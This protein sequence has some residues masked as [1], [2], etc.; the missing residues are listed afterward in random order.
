MQESKVEEILLAPIN[1]RFMAKS[2]E[3]NGAAARYPL[4]IRFLHFISGSSYFSTTVE[5]LFC[6]LGT[7]SFF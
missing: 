2:N 7:S 6:T 1:V 5:K 4:A 3:R